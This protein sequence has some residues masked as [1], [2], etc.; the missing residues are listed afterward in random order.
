MLEHT[1][2]IGH[3]PLLVK[4]LLVAAAV[5]ALRELRRRDDR[6]RSTDDAAALA[7][8]EDVR[9]TLVRLEERVG[10]L[11]TLLPGSPGTNTGTT[12]HSGSPGASGRDPRQP[13]SPG[14]RGET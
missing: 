10:N 14:K 9:A 1:V 6:A 3:V 5:L 2:Y 7:V 8:L 11:E 12:R 4:V 13:W